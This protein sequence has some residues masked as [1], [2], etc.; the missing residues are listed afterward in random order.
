MSDFHARESSQREPVLSAIIATALSRR[1]F[2]LQSGTAGAVAFVSLNSTPA[3][4][5]PSSKPLG[6][7]KDAAA[8]DSN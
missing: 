1:Q 2:L 5:E 7:D 3:K 8:V 4:A 6:V